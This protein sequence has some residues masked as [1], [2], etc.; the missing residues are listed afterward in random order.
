MSEVIISGGLKPTPKDER[1]FKLGAL[2]TLPKLSDLPESFEHPIIGI[3]NQLDTD[4]CSAF[5]S[6]T[7]SELQEGTT[8]EPTWSF[9]VSKMIS[10]DLDEF[11]QDLRTAMSVH[12]KYGAIEHGESPYHIDNDANLTRNIVLWPQGLF[13][14]AIKHKK[15]SYLK[16]TGPYDDFDNIRATIYKFKNEK[17][18]VVFGVI[19]GW[20]ASQEAI[21]SVPTFGGGH[22]LAITGWKKDKLVVVNS[23]GPTAGNGGKH[24]FSREVINKMVGEYGAYMFVDLSPE[25][26]KY[27]LERGVK[28]DD[29][30]FTLFIRAIKKFFKL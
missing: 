11:G 2:Y 29:G 30:F 12:T 7:V 27:Y 16:V 26:V 5:A 25:E 19:W 17:R 3:K 15:R 4:Y 24:L 13:N 28:Y 1:D 20:P 21:D 18:G 10:G 22:A 23:Y 14:K 9:A 6:C 8:L